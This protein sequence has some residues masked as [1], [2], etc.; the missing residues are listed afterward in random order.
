MAKISW[1]GTATIKSSLRHWTGKFLGIRPSNFTLPSGWVSRS[2]T[3]YV[4]GIDLVGKLV[5]YGTYFSE[6]DGRCMFQTNGTDQYEAW[7]LP[8]LTDDIRDR[9]RFKI[10]IGTESVTFVMDN[11]S[12]DAAGP[13]DWVPDNGSEVKSFVNGLSTGNHNVTVELDD[14]FTHQYPAVRP[15]QLTITPYP[16]PALNEGESIALSYSYTGGRYD[17]V[18][19]EPQWG[20]FE[21][22]GSFSSATGQTTTFTA[23]M[24][25]NDKR[26]T[27]V[28]GGSVSG[29]GVRYRDETVLFGRL[30]TMQIKNVL[31]KKMYHGS[32]KINK[33]YQGQFRVSKAY[34][35]RTL[36]FEK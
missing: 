32:T 17:T 15:P 23:P 6:S 1:T 3:V 12:K 22:E 28:C 34:W 27:I 10:T 35:G 2:N 36:V 20:T 13:Y 7:T 29:N 24:V 5:S 16:L 9:L 21:N 25:S 30:P 18:E 33:M 4:V 19:Q 26:I 14:G 8:S 11:T 31:I